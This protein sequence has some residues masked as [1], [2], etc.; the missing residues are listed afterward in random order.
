MRLESG[1]WRAAVASLATEW[2]AARPWVGRSINTGGFDIAG[3]RSPSRSAFVAGLIVL[4]LVLLR[5][6]LGSAAMRRAALPLVVVG[7]GLLFVENL[8]Q[9]G[10]RTAVAI[11]AA[12]AAS[13][14][15][16]WPLAA[17]PSLAAEAAALQRR[18]DDE[19]WR[20]RIWVYGAPGFFR[21]YPTWLLRKQDAATLTDPDQLPEQA[22]LANF[23]IVL[24][25][26]G[27]WDFDPSL[28]RVRI[29]RQ[30][31]AAAPYF[32]GA[33]LRVYRIEPRDRSAP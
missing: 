29:G 25:G 21:E 32:E 20:P 22:Q 4:S 17:Q 12:G 13:R 10:A 1:S 5:L 2:T 33:W 27:D 9:H 11:E 3:R 6:A 14:H 30:T 26:E 7:V 31:R 28:E 24:V 15:P 19:P 23:L 18:I 8:L 16:E